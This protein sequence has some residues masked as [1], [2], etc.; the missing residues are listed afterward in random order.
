[1][2]RDT[3]MHHRCRDVE[4]QRCGSVEGRG[5][6]FSGGA[7]VLQRLIIVIGAEVQVQQRCRIESMNMCTAGAEVL[8]QVQS[9]E[10]EVKRC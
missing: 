2:Q 3:E 7:E 6:K 9:S 5:A 1:M 10:E 8:K 4:V